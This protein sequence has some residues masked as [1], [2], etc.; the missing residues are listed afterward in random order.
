[1]FK[2]RRLTRQILGSATTTLVQVLEAND[3]RLWAA[4]ECDL[5]TGVAM[6]VVFSHEYTSSAN[7]VQ[8]RLQ[9]GERIVLSNSTGGD[10]PWFGSVYVSGVG[11]TAGYRGGE[12]YLERT[13]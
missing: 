1:M 10:M 9:P 5:T 7:Y 12:V 4:I 13:G 2:Y 8:F 11:A 6:N 3:L